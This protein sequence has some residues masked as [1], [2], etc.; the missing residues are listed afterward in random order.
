MRVQRSGSGAEERE[1]LHARRQAADELVEAGEGRGP[2]WFASEG[3]PERADA[4][5][6]H[7]AERPQR[8]AAVARQRRVR[9]VLDAALNDHPVSIETTLGAFEQFTLVG[10]GLVEPPGGDVGEVEG[11]GE[12]G[13]HGA[14][15]SVVNEPLDLDVRTETLLEPAHPRAARSVAD[16]ALGMRDVGEVADAKHGLLGN[17][18]VLSD[19]CKSKKFTRAIIDIHDVPP[20]AY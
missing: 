7:V 12:E 3:E 9:D 11:A 18:E 4:V 16:H 19:L 15:A 17:F 6:A 10:A 2:Q 8:A 20:R 13:L 5:A 14:G 1:R